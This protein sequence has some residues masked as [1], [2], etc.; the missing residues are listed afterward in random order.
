MVPPNL[1]A[2]THVF[3]RLSFSLGRGSFRVYLVKFHYLNSTL[4]TV[5][6]ECFG[7]WAGIRQSRFEAASLLSQGSIPI[8]AEDLRYL[9]SGIR[10]IAIVFIGAR[11]RMN[12]AA[13]ATTWLVASTLKIVK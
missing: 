13:T 1:L 9:V 7:D 5:G 10:N 4:L 3:Y 8:M 11:M 6:Q 2:P 12:P